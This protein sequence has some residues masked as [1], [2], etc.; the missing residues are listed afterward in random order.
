MS[1][2]IVKIHGMF[3]IGSFPVFSHS[4]FFLFFVI[5]SHWYLAMFVAA[6]GCPAGYTG[7]GGISEDGAYD[8]CTG[9][10]YRYIDV[11]L[12]GEDHIYHGSAV[13][14]VYGGQNFECEGFM[15]MMN[16]V[17]MTYLGTLISW[18]FLN[19]KKPWYVVLTYLSVGSLLLLVGGLLCGFKQFD[20][21]MPI[22]KNKWNTTFV[23]ITSGTGFVAFGIIYMMVDVLKVWSGYPY[24]AVGMN[25]ILIYVVHEF[26]HGYIPFTYSFFMS[27][28]G[29]YR[30]KETNHWTT[31]ANSYLLGVGMWIAIGNYLYRQKVFVKI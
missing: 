4:R 10:I 30:F 26:V 6:P 28:I 16:A 22:N 27:L 18:I 31:M 1:S 14:S 15:G 2:K 24:R 12:L 5:I 17:F 3:L 11:K 19:I 29:R 9:G 25:S 21:Y 7:P 8:G 20:G 23:M 13:T